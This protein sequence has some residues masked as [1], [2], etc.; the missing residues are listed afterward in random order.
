VM[1][2]VVDAAVARATV[3]AARPAVAIAELTEQDLVILGGKVNLPV[4]PRPLVI[5]H[6][7]VGRVTKCRRGRTCD[8]HNP[9]YDIE[10][11]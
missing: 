2:E 1:V 11:Q 9:K 8:H 4:M 3:L 7:P 10:G 5:V 6:H